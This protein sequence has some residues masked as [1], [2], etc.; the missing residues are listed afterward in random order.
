MSFRSR[1]RGLL[2]A[3]SGN[4]AATA[5]FTPLTYNYLGATATAGL[6][7]ANLPAVGAAGAGTRTA[8]IW[9]TAGRRDSNTTSAGNYLKNN[10]TI[11]LI[12]VRATSL[13]TRTNVGGM[14]IADTWISTDL[15]GA[16]GVGAADSMQAVTGIM[17]KA[18]FS[19]KQR[20]TS[21]VT[22]SASPAVTFDAA[23]ATGGEVVVCLHH[24]QAQN[25]VITPPAGSVLL[26]EAFTTGAGGTRPA[27]VKL[28]AITSNMVGQTVVPGLTLDTSRPWVYQAIEVGP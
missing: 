11:G 17:V 3:G 7:T 13:T 22:T 1:N 14:D 25:I 5:S 26:G 18:G 8:T 10:S 12:T 20:K 21:A 2:R 15:I 27:G 9:T 6:S 19:V 24:A 23:V 28:Y 16:L 4:V